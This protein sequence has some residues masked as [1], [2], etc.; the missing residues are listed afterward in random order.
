[1]S[2]NDKS[3]MMEDGDELDV[4]EGEDMGEDEDDEMALE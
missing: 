3:D 4:D 2:N 1:M